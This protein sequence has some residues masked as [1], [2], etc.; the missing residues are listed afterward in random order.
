MVLRG[1]SLTRQFSEKKIRGV[2][3]FEDV[4]VRFAVWIILYKYIS[5]ALLLCPPIEPLKGVLWTATIH[6]FVI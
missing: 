3:N 4:L 5:F 1:K 2:R 6:F